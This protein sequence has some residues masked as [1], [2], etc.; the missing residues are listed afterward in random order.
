MGDDKT[1][2]Y[3]VVIDQEEAE[4]SHYGHNQQTVVA[5][6]GIKLSPT[7]RAILPIASYCFASIL[8]TVTNKYVLSGYE[9]NM[10]FLLLTIQ[11]LVTVFLLVVFKFFNLIK[12]RDFD[13]D[14]A[15]KWL[16]VAVS[17]VGMIYTGSKALQYLRIPIYTIF[18]NLTII[19]IAYGEVLWFGGRV[20]HLMLIS[21]GLMV[22][23]SVIAGWADISE[24]LSEIVQLDTTIAGYFWMATN[25]I[26]SAA[27]VL[28]MR[29]RIK[30]TNF[31]DFD[32]VFYNNILSIPFLIIPSFIFEDWSAENLAINFPSD[33]RQQVVT[34]MIFS[35]ASAFAM[36]YASAWCVRTTSSTTYS[37]VGALNK[38]PI[39]A[40]GI[41]FF[42]DPATFG[43]VTAIIVGF[44]AG[45]VYSVAKT[46]PNS[47]P[48]NNKEIIPMSSSSQSNIDAT[49][50]RLSSTTGHPLPLESIQQRLAG[51]WKSMTWPIC[52][53][54]VKANIALTIAFGLFLINPVR[55]LT[56]ASGILAAVAVEFVHPSKSYGFLAEDVV[57]GSLMCCLV[58][59]W[60][61]LVR[62][63]TN[64]TMAQ[65]KVCAILMFFL[66]IGC[67]FLSIIRVRV[68]KAN[69][70]VYVEQLIKH[71]VNAFLQSEHHVDSVAVIH[72]KVDLLKRMVRREPSYNVIATTDQ[73]HVPLRGLGISQRKVMERDN[74]QDD[75]MHIKR[76]RSYYG[77]TDDEEEA[78]ALEVSDSEE[79]ESTE[80]NETTCSSQ[81]LRQRKV[82]WEDSMKVITFWK[83]D[84]DEILNVVRPTYVHLALACSEA[85][86][87]SIK[88]LRRMQS[89]DPRYQG[90]PFFYKYYYRWKVGAEREKEEEKAFYY[91]PSVDPSIPLYEAIRQFHEQR[92]VG[93]NRLYTSTGVPRRILFLLLT[94][95][96]NLHTF[97]KLLY[98]L[99]SLIYELDLNR[100]RR[101]L[102]WPHLSFTK[103]LFQDHQ[104]EAS[105]DLETPAAIAGTTHPLAIQESLRRR[106]TVIAASAATHR[107][108]SIVDLE[109]QLQKKPLYKLE[110]PYRGRIR[111]PDE[112][113]QG[114]LE[115]VAINPWRRN[116][117]DPMDYHDPDAAYPTTKRQHFFYNVYLFIVQY[118]YTADAAFA[119]RAI[120][121]VV[122]LSLP[123]FLEDSVG[124]YSESR[125][126]WAVVVALI[127]MGPSVGS[128][129]FATATRTVGTFIGAIQSIIIW[130]IARGTI[131]G[132]IIL[133]FF[134]NLPWWL[135]YI[136]GKFWK[137]SGLFALVTTSLILGYT[138]NLDEGSNQTTIFV[139]TYQRAVTC[140]VGV[141]AALII[142]AFPYPRTGR[143]ELRHRISNTISDLGSLY[144]TFLALL[145]RDT[146][147]DPETRR[148]DRAL[149]QAIANSIRQQIKG[150]R[151]LLDQSRFEPTLRGTFPAQKYLYLLQVLD[152]I[153]GLI[154]GMEFVIQKI[155]F[156]WRMMVV[157]DTWQARKQMIASYLTALHL[158]SDA[159][160]NKSPLPPY[161]VRPTKARRTLTNL[162]RRMDVFKVQHL[163]EREY[164]YYSTYMMNSEQL[165][166]ELELLVATVRDLV[167]PDSV[168][169]WLNY[170]H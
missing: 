151:V 55:Q 13:K 32:T 120:I 91:D 93:L 74:Q 17:L 20:T 104:T 61:I 135:V 131:P 149:F 38:L 31:K 106:A 100:S 44:I 126:Q 119:F 36:S 161:V 167:G 133:T 148:A 21:F 29:K 25:C 128:N 82:Q 127:W 76:P 72:K 43:N 102:W 164:T 39:A 140:L 2:E 89:L 121:V 147:E 28:Y 113:R 26:T 81:Q 68:E 136:N 142:S 152:N 138:Y 150:E 122:A 99:T 85:V 5:P 52:V 141:L 12:F 157:K 53:K 168:S 19:L 30:L 166:V 48:Q 116:A 159:L 118:V 84:Y 87:E 80:S 3:K 24:T 145:V 112:H 23:S 78:E 160:T 57:Y 107:Q 59:A 95:Q 14:E 96:F 144:S 16:P 101:Q 73:L 139:I 64:K 51:L 94:F 60:S 86:K 115:K 137:A 66:I 35:G 130:E 45:I 114:H 65:P 98:T 18:K 88:R 54:I 58:A 50:F 123:A 33:I 117:L 124:W 49:R 40:S 155:S 67:F 1:K 97:A 83:T 79:E 169:I 75:E 111:T 146:P 125:G 56:G 154:I 163:G 129:F 158:S 8:M 11:N 69:V 103:W 165:S 77:G 37:M 162:A 110:T 63:Q 22:L 41:L 109:S 62:D 108:S 132:L 7:A 143:V 42:G 134:V 153:L 9:F 34:A 70:G 46:S 10:N 156:E 170:K 105:F 6:S 90:K 27:F 15:R 47:T 71:Q 92:L 4:N